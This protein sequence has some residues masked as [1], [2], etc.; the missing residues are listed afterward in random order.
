MGFNTAM[1]SKLN[2]V[3]HGNIAIYFDSGIK[4]VLKPTHYLINEFLGKHRDRYLATAK[5]VHIGK[6][7]GRV[8]CQRRSGSG[9]NRYIKHPFLQFHIFLAVF[10]Q[11]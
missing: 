5:R 7:C 2:I 8:F 10:D 3:V 4:W 6:C 9:A 11:N 1:K